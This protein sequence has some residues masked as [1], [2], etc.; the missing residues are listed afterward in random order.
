MKPLLVLLSTIAILGAVF[1]GGCSV[2]SVGNYLWYGPRGEY[3]SL[4]RD[5]AWI[6]AGVGL[7]AAAV[8]AANVW[9][10]RTFFG[11][12][13]PWRRPCAAALAFMDVASAALALA[14]ILWAD[15]WHWA[16]WPGTWLAKVGAGLL[17][18]KGVLIW[19]L[20]GR[21]ATAATDTRES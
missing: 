9:V 14:W 11:R 19:R 10:V 8:L 2:V 12:P 20:V 5:I 15:T 17:A 16:E 18:L 4:Q 3:P 6:S 1:A 13:S 21:S 7:V